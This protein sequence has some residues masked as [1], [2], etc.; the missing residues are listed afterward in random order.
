MSIGLDEDHAALSDAVRGFVSRHAAS[1]R[2]RA[3][4]ERWVAGAAPD[5]WQAIV[6]QGL[7]SLHLP[8][9]LGGA[10]A[11]AV[12]LAVVVEESA[13]GLLPGPL[14]PSVLTSSVLARYG[15]DS[16]RKRLLPVL[17]AGTTGATA[18]AANGVTATPGPDGTYRVAGTTL[19]VLGAPG[20]AILLLGATTPDGDEIWFTAEPGGG[21]EA[22]AG[23]PVDHTRAVGTVTLTDVT[24]GPEQVLHVHAAQIRAV[25]A[26]LFAAEAVGLA[27]W[28][29]TTGIDYAKIREQFGRP[30]G[31]FQAIKHK[32]ARLF[33]DVETMSASAWDAARALE[34]DDE[35]LAI[36]AAGAA[37]ACLPRATEIGLET[38]TLLGGIGY[39]WEHDA[40][41]YWRRAMVLE[42]LL[43]PIDDWEHLTGELVQHTAR[44]FSIDLSHA[45][46]TFRARIAGVLAEV[47][48]LPADGPARRQRLADE[49]LVV[50]HYPKP[51]G[52][53]ATPVEQLVI[54]QEYERSGVTQPRLIIGDWALP[55]ILAHG[56]QEQKDYFVPPTLRGDLQWC[57]LFSE[58]GAGSD[59]AALST[60]AVK[61]DGGWLLT[62]QKVWNTGTREA[63]YG[64]CLART[65]PAAPK[66]KGISYFLVDMAAPGL[67]IRPL[68]E[69]NG[70][71][72]FNE[73]FL[74]D[75]FVPDRHLVGEVNGGWA[76]A[77]TTLGNERVSISGM[78][79]IPTQ[80]LDLAA[81]G[82][83]ASAPHD[84]TREIGA[85][86]ATAHAL[87]AMALRTTQRTLSGLRPGAESSVS[88]AASGLLVT[89]IGQRSMRWFGAK[90]ALADGPA[91]ERVD[92][93]L[94]VPTQLIGGGTMEIQLNV[95]AERILG[96]PRG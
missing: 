72:L 77:R 83:L 44:D 54:Q 25:A 89:Q 66:H 58:P 69:A 19:P 15:D 16:L 75:V 35:Q 20:A 42:N 30:I 84:T 12:A 45:D 7:T 2:V 40:H 90:A 56:T 3:G 80:L 6:E 67:D 52:L 29:V 62:G 65:D 50:P 17:A 81:S 33:I 46:D 79:H 5:Y 68:R 36:A 14:L 11:G 37:V 88:K 26:V 13:R 91:G 87:A 39:T 92:R 28:C 86:F 34:Q 21:V 9:D 38:I 51:Y 48:A 53:A 31:S 73:V 43:G 1:E 71:Y 22:T 59:L 8:E 78:Q 94:S 60:R 49:G 41:F 85:M 55:T 32:C 70:G 61:T 27:R 95:I 63:D 82:E 18:L 57:Q 76:L 64:I 10:G 24:V 47:A 93:Y 96:L 74:D 23:A 4:L